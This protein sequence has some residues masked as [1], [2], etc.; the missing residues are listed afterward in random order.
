MAE[1]PPTPKPLHGRRLVL[2][3]AGLGVVGVLVLGARFV[4]TV[5]G[6]ESTDDAFVEGHVALV[7][8]EVSGRVIEVA[9]EDNDRVRAGQVLVRLDAAEYEARVAKAQ[10]DLDAATNRET[11]AHSAAASAEADGRVAATELWRAKQDVERV[12]SLFERGVASRQQLDDA[13]AKRDSAVARVAAATNRADSERAMLGNSAQ[14]KQAEAALRSAELDLSHTQVVAPFDGVIG[15]KN[16]ERGA[17]V[18]PGQPLV[19]VTAAVPP[20]VIAN[21]K[22]TQIARIRPGAKAEVHV[23]AFPDVLWKGHVDS[24][25]AATGATYAL[26]PPDNATGNFTKVV[27]RVPVKIVL[28][29]PATDPLRVGL[30]AQVRVGGH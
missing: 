28:D 6:G 2:F 20:W 9:V 23:D 29:E 26:I 14:V 22:E 8:A 5:F 17:L 12:Q 1:R 16:V 18:G 27:Q 7:G 11:A 19:A 25:A 13:V 24:I 4:G 21:F 10:A 15:R 30:S 3:V